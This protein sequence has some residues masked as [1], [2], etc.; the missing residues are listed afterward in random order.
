MNDKTKTNKVTFEELFSYE[1]WNKL[2]FI[3]GLERDY[4]YHKKAHLYHGTFSDAGDAVCKRGWNRDNGEA[5]SIWSNN[6][7][8]DGVCKICIKKAKKII[9]EREKRGIK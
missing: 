7:G 1:Y 8:E 9:A 6:V 2:G 5:Y 4:P 3:A